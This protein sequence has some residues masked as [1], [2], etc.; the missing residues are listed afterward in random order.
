MGIF[1]FLIIYF[2]YIVITVPLIGIGVVKDSEGNY[3]VEGIDREGRASNLNISQGDVILQVD[4]ES[5]EDDY[6]VLK[7]HRVEKALN[8]LVEHTDGTVEEIV[9]DREWLHSLTGQEL[10]FQI[11]VPG[12]THV[13]FI[14]M[15]W[16]LYRKKKEKA[17]LLLIMFFLSIGITY[18]SS[19]ASYRSDPLAK[20]C[21]YVLLPMVP[22][23]YIYFMNTY[24]RKYNAVFFNGKLFK[25]MVFINSLCSIVFTIYVLTDWIPFDF[26]DASKIMLAAL[27]VMGF[28]SCL[29]ALIK[30]YIQFHRT[31]LN[32]LFKI[33]LASHV[34][35]FTPFVT[36]NLLP[37]IIFNVELLTSTL[38]TLCIFVLPLS[39]MYLFSSNT[40]FDIDFIFTRFKYYTSIAI[41]PAVGVLLF[42]TIIES[43]DY[44]KSWIKWFQIFFVI[45][46]GMTLFLYLKEQIDYRFRPKLFK[47]MYSFQDSL[48]RFSAQMTRVMKRSD[49]EDV[50]KQEMSAMLPLSTFRMLTVNVEEQVIDTRDSEPIPIKLGHEL[51]QSVETYRVSSIN[52]M[53]DGLALVVGLRKEAYHIIWISN[54]NNHTSFNVDELRWLKTITHYTSIVHENLYLIETLL[55]DLE[56]EMHKEKETPTWLLRLLF[57]LSEN[58]R[59]K[60]ASDLHDSALQDQLLWFR[61]LESAMID[62]KMSA[63]LQEELGHIR[64]G[65]LDVVYQIRETCNELRPPLLKEL[66]LIKALE[67]LI[68]HMQLQVNFMVYFHAKPIHSAL[69]EEQLTVIYRIIQELLRNT[70][71]HA[72]ANEV[73]IDLKQNGSY[74]HLNYKDD[75]IGMN[76][77]EMKASFSHMGLSGVKERVV[78]LEGKIEFHSAVG[79]GFKVNIILPIVWTIGRGEREDSHDSYLIG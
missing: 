27:L 38:T 67:S 58:E 20:L 65:L 26:L 15:S 46:A 50:L 23:I 71:K 69:N 18:F 6:S 24:L 4:G 28:L 57:T 48:D 64:E 54:K 9:F 45:Y 47:Q 19:P 17:T 12:L 13:I 60:L 56:L 35:A 41:I 74:I 55:E 5:P 77:G 70:A 16:F 42:L 2:L 78:S 36:M 79:Q 75:G 72:R 53:K 43:I 68:E 14:L 29:L 40:L 11:I 34:V 59:R 62:Y 21:M 1:F 33:M 37:L 61:R 10:I 32:A 44:D 22:Y 63:E 39:Y 30:V 73:V 31:R 7:F 66:G 8:I 3:V 49:L 76:L 51:L 52:T 25:F